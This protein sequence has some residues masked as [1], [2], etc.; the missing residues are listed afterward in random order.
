MICVS[1]VDNGPGIA[2]E[3]QEKI[4]EI[5]QQVEPNTQKGEGLGLS[6]AHKIVAR[7]NGRIW[8]ESELG[9]GSKFFVSFPS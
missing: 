3:Y 9:K 8:V 6:I 5:F 2:P 7:N 1:V 4:F